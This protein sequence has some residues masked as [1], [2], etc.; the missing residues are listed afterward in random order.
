MPR[1]PSPP[2]DPRGASCRLVAGL[3]PAIDAVAARA[4]M[5]HAFLRHGWF[6]AALDAY[7]GAARTL[8]VERD[9]TP[10]IALPLVGV[11]PPW[12]RAAMIPG[13]YWPFR[14]FPAATD[15]G[16]AD[17]APALRELAR[18]TRVL[19]IGPVYEDDPA[20]VPLI[21]SARA[22][23]WAAIDRFVADSWVLNME[24]LRATGTWPRGSTLRKNRF[25]EKHL[26]THGTPEWRFLSGADWPAAFGALAHI[27]QVSWIASR[28]DGRDAKFTDGGR[29]AFWRGVASDPVLAD[30][31]R[32]ALLTIDGRP[33]AFSFDLDVGELKYAIANSYD[34]AFAK[35]SPGKLLYWRNL[36]EALGRGISRVDWGAGDSGYKQVIGAERGP[37]LRDWLLVRPGVSAWAARRL[38]GWWRRSGQPRQAFGHTS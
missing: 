12:C 34:P 1:A 7:G 37:A 19:R 2:P 27:E 25:H 9:G 17:L 33:A 15:A 28:T 29:G 21:D 24:E 31:M 3:D 5:R 4:P 32:A 30:M 26:A 36:V 35:H 14:S 10:V 22:A 6:A 16:A 18:T 13:A 23:G 11:G 20:V 38:A 8:L